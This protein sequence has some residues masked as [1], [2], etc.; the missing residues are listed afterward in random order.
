MRILL[1]LWLLITSFLVQGQVL[2]GVVESEGKPLEG[3]AIILNKSYVLSDSNGKFQINLVKGTNTISIT[4]ISTFDFKQVLNIKS[5]TTII[6]NLDKKVSTLNAVEVKGT[7]KK[8]TVTSVISTIRNSSSVSDGIS[9]ETIKKT[10]DRN[11]GESLRRISGITVQ[12]DKFIVVRGLADRYNLSMMDGGLLPSTE[13]DRRTFSYDIIPNS[14]IDNVIVIKSPSAN[15]PGDFSGGL[16]QLTTKSTYV[17]SLNLSALIGTNNLLFNENFESVK[18]VNFPNNFPSTQKFKSSDISDRKTYTT[19]ISNPNSYSLNTYPNLNLNLNGSQRIGDVSSIFSVSSSRNN[20]VIYSN[21]LEYFSPNELAYNYNDTGYVQSYSIN[22]LLNL[23]Y[24]KGIKLNWKN[25]FNY[26]SENSFINRT[27]ENYD[28]L[29][30]V[31]LQSSN[32]VNKLLFNS[33]IDFKKD[34]INGTIGYNVITRDQPDYRIN[35]LQRSI[36]TTDTFSTVWRDSYRF[37]STMY[38]SGFNG[39][40]NYENRGFKTGVSY[41]NKNRYF[42]ARVFRYQSKDLLEEITNNTDRYSANFYT[43]S[44]Y[45]MYDKSLNKWKF[46]GGL[47]FEYNSFGVETSDFGGSDVIVKNNYP[48]LLP[49]INLSYMI[50]EKNKI[51]FSASRSVSRPELRE[52]SNFT[53]YDFVRN[54]QIIGNPN[55]TIANISNVD[56]KWEKNISN[57]ETFSFGLFGKQFDNPIEMIVDAGSVPSNLLLSYKNSKSAILFGGELDFRKNVFKWMTLYSNVSLIYSNVKTETGNRPLQGQSPYNINIASSFNYRKLSS[58]ISYNRTGERIS[59][60]G[61]QGYSDIYENSRDIIDITT[62]YKL[63]NN[64]EFKLSLGNILGQNMKFYQKDRELPLMNN[65]QERTINLSLNV[66]IK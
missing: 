43:M 8:E 56:M 25:I 29:Q 6:F 57:S 35:P 14:I 37:W 32:T 40:L 13:P 15:L 60:V 39:T 38:E 52:I 66:K 50:T 49:S 3:A 23:S 55:L 34:N 1:T 18:S 61:F 21:R 59:L 48:S 63:N 7:Y 64:F 45:V 36:G 20:S 22:G 42:Q 2:N 30:D 17:N 54:A 12:D 24:N 47:R 4:H 46:N 28:N 16:V 53:Y 19:L 5:D 27:G 62:I 41:L 11:M 58:T 44:S 33:L 31:R 9:I 10:P 65:R 51:R 26:N